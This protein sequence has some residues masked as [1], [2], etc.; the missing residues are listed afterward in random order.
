[1][2]SDPKAVIKWITLLLPSSSVPALSSKKHT[3]VGEVE[4]DGINQLFNIGFVTSKGTAEKLSAGAKCQL[5]MSYFKSVPRLG[6]A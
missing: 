3:D 1:M 4:L 5:K 6:L 2:I